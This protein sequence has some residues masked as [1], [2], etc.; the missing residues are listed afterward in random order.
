MCSFDIASSYTNVPV[1]ESIAVIL[2][3]LFANDSSLY[4]GFTRAEFKK[5]LELTLMY[6][7]F[8][9]NGSIYKQ[10]TGLSMGSPISPLIA[11][12]FLNKFET[13]ILNNCPVNFKTQFYKRYVDDSFL[14]FKDKQQSKQFFNYINNK[15]NNIKFTF[16]GESEQC[17]P[18]LDVFVR[19]TEN[20][21]TTSIFRKRTF[22]GLGTNFFS[23][24]TLKYKTA[25][26]HTLIN[27]A[28][29]ICSSY[30]LFH[31]EV[32]FLK[33]Y[34]AQNC[35]PARLFN[36]ILKKF[37]NRQYEST[38][39]VHTVAKRKVYVNLP[40]I[41]TQTNKMISEIRC[42]LDQFYPQI[43]SCF[44]HKNNY[45]IGSLFK[46]YESPE[47]LLRS[48]V[49]YKYKCHCCQQCY[50]GSTQLQMFRRIAQHKGVSFRTNRPL[51]KLDFS[52]IR[53]HCNNENHSF[54]VDNFSIVDSC[55]FSYDLKLLESIVINQE[56]PALNRNKLATP[57]QI[58]S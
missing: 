34:F 28:Y 32:I 42:L 16:E 7:Y 18:F 30:K 55:L 40:Y 25:S 39:I 20:M 53:D 10:I 45:T 44:Y 51:A 23:N 41:G 2:D 12:I 48:C 31:E 29:K 4:E 19:R 50:I 57:L 49:V 27:R 37:L 33:T 47:L 21:F 38:T 56:K 3:C 36:S 6:S 13:S 17:L 1:N 22:T 46:R 52:S 15:H 11:N 14:L 8:K 54:K 43:H 58:L 5:L 26:I 24:L 9:F 35:Y